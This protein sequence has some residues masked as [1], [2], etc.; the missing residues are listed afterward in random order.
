MKKKKSVWLFSPAILVLILGACTSALPESPSTASDLVFVRWNARSIDLGQM[1][2]I[3]I[4]NGTDK[5]IY[6]EDMKSDCSIV[7]LERWDGSAW[8]EIPGCVERRAPGAVK[9]APGQ[10]YSVA[11][12]P[13]SLNFGVNPEVSTTA[14]VPSTY[15]IRFNYRLEAEPEGEEPYVSFSEILSVGSE[16]SDQ[17]TVVPQTAPAETG[18]PTEEFG[19]PMAVVSGQVTVTVSAGSFGIGEA[20]EVV[21][22]NG[23]DQTLY[24]ADMKTG[25]TI[26][27]LEKWE[28]GIWQA[29]A[30]CPMQR[31]P[32]VFA[33]APGY[34]YRATLD[35]KSDFFGAS[36]QAP[37]FTEGTYRIRFSHRLAPEPEGEEPLTVYSQEFKILP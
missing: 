14:I 9:I 17:I 4:Q 13:D 15:R 30:G 22:A 37:A 33:L 12:D 6:A 32:L 1:I 36:P 34:G 31:A 26:F 18:Q 19:E 23:L 20:I 10:E 25:C 7:F 8:H 29:V 5:P 21:V 3:T 27:T 2:E 24:T 11:I 28:T 35:P 16:I